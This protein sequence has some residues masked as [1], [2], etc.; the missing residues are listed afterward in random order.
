[1]C[2]DAQ[3]F[4]PTLHSTQVV[5]PRVVASCRMRVVDLSAEVSV[6]G[7]LPVIEALLE[8]ESGV[9]FEQYLEPPVR[10]VL[11]RLGHD[12][13]FVAVHMHH[14]RALQHL[15]LHAQSCF[16]VQAYVLSVC[17]CAQVVFDG[18]SSVRGLSWWG[19]AGCPAETLQSASCEVPLA[20]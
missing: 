10:A 8:R 5:E 16:L 2:V 4:C 1:M 11:A 17:L 3:L 7:S 9:P 18:W 13:H 20:C 19:R 6:K 15:Y 12:E 14:V